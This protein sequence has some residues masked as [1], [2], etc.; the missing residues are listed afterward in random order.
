[1]IQ[2]IE[3]W[4]LHGEMISQG[5]NVFVDKAVIFHRTFRIHYSDLRFSMDRRADSEVLKWS[6]VNLVWM[7]KSV[8]SKRVVRLCL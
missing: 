7:L 1:M 8:V 4:Y 2:G 3:N 6:S 5:L